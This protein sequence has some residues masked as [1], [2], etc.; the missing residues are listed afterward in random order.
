VVILIADD[1]E[2]HA[3]LT[4]KSM[5]RAG[6][7]NPTMVFRNGEQLLDFLFERDPVFKLEE[8]TAYL[9]LLDLMMPGVSGV[10]VLRQIKSHPELKR[11]PVFMLTSMD[12]PEGIDLCYNLGCSAYIIKPV[13]AKDFGEA[14]RKIGLYLTVAEI[15]PVRRKG[16]HG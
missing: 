12:D 14:V 10:E 16:T 15:P 3:T 11:I 1:D 13:D 2:G 7:S 5:K 8:D 9:L 6:I 4:C